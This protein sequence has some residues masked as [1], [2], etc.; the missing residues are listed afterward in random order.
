MGTGGEKERVGSPQ[1]TTVTTPPSTET[2]PPPSVTVETIPP[3]ER[4][5]ELLELPISNDPQTL[6]EQLFTNYEAA[7]NTNDSRYLDYYVIEP[8]SEIGNKMREGM[9][10][11][12]EARRAE[13]ALRRQYDARVLDDPVFS[14]GD[15]TRTMTVEINE[16][17][18][19]DRDGNSTA[20]RY[21]YKMT[22]KPVERFIDY[23]SGA[24]STKV[25]LVSSVENLGQVYTAG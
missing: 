22:L 18:Q 25:W 11:N 4:L 19:F 15:L 23:G 10:L 9:R 7:F 8:N 20:Y 17:A 2:L 16:L 6:A 13:P 14:S 24:T 3:V 12:A 5:P 1:K 21:I